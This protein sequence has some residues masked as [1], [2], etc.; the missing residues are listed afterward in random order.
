VHQEN[1]NHT[2]ILSFDINSE[3]GKVRKVLKVEPTRDGNGR[4]FNLSM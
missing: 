4:F 3:E 1:T 2:I